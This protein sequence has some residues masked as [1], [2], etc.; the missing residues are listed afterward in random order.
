MRNLFAWLTCVVVLLLAPSVWAQS[1]PA[2]ELTPSD[3]KKESEEP[4][5]SDD[6]ASGEASGSETET[7]SPQGPQCDYHVDCPA[8]H[9]CWR[10]SCVQTNE[11]LNLFESANDTCGADRRCR[12]ERLKRKNRA[13]RHVQKLEEER[14]A[15]TIIEREQADKLESM[16]RRHKPLA[17]DLRASRMGVA[18]LVGGYTLLGKLRPE[19]HFVHWGA[20]VSVDYNDENYSGF[21][22]T[23]FLI[24]GVYYF[25]LDS[26]FTPYGS[27][28]FLYG[29]G[30]FDR[31][32][33][34][35][36]RSPPG[37]GGG[38]GTVPLEPQEL[39]TEYHAI[40][41]GA[42]VDYQAEDLGAHLRLGFTYRPLI[43]NQARTG[44]GQ[45][46]EP[47]RKALEN[48]FQQMARI[49]FVVLAGW[50]F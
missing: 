24:P 10:G 29:W 38:G 6:G 36:S 19:L 14:Y 4:S 21:Q 37:G 40:E 16:P 20:D 12:I 15:E 26:E 49:D 34:G 33:S 28:S 2:I 39:D 32:N 5:Q 25:F 44:P 7:Q 50:A 47:T 48:W 35:I 43:Y 30:T 13:R 22:P 42:G 31:Y 45:Y 27:A 3:E 41:L 9:V 1:D 11:A 17:F 8:E 18:G 23:T 46:S